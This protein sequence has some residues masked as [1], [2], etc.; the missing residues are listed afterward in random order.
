[1]KLKTAAATLLTGLT[2]AGVLL[3]A[4]PTNAAATPTE[5]PTITVSW[6]TQLAPSVTQPHNANDVT[7]PQTI[8][9]DAPCGDGW[10]QVDVYRYSEKHKAAVDALIAHGILNKPGSPEWTDSAFVK[11]WSFHKLDL[12]EVQP[13]PP[14]FGQ[15]T[16]ERHS[17]LAVVPGVKGVKY[18]LDGTEVAEGTYPLT[19]GVHTI[20]AT[21][22][23]GWRFPH[24]QTVTW[25]LEIVV[26]GDCQ[27]PTPTPTPTPSVTPTNPV[28]PA[29]SVP[30]S[31]P[32]KPVTH[33]TTHQSAIPIT[34]PVTPVPH[35]Q[36][37]ANTGS[38][39]VWLL[40]LTGLLALTGGAGLLVA[41]YRRQH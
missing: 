26:P 9:G 32:V 4:T 10:V 24:E 36:E 38:G 8:A 11:S 15:G 1:M 19:L 31:H 27:T 5:Q 35:R 14:G 39:Q 21:P 25:S 17:G 34:H 6:L 22:R 2:A 40:I 3:T 37:L 13:E 7:W 41:Q 18:T 16:C 12:C 28:T 20:V 29:P 33:H 30:S 23:P